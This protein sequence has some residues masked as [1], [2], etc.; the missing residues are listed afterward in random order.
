MIRPLQLILM[1]PITS[2]INEL[3]FYEIYMDD[4]RNVN[5]YLLKSL[6]R[7]QVSLETILW[8]EADVFWMIWSH[9]NSSLQPTKS[10]IIGGSRS[11]S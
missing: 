9:T 11:H 3:T 10:S 8:A 7:R 2:T 4:C 6:L 1:M 5:E